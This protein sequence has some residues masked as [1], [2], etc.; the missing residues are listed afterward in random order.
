MSQNWP[1]ADGVRVT[2]AGRGVEPRRMAS[3]SAARGAA[4]DRGVF[5]PGYYPTSA[6]AV[7]FVHVMS[8]R[9]HFGEPRGRIGRCVLQERFPLGRR[10]QFEM[11]RIVAALADELF[12]ERLLEMR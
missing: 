2:A 9:F 7:N 5:T 8:A 6:I 10:Q 12:D 4:F 11:C 1:S 3:A